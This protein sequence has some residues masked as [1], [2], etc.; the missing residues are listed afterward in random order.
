MPID[1]CQH[2]A[3]ILKDEK[4]SPIAKKR[5]IDE[6]KQ[7]L[8]LGTAGVPTPPLPCGAQ[9]P[10]VPYADLIELEDESKYPEW[11]K[12][13]LGLYEQ[14]AKGLDVKSQF[15]ILPIVDP[16]ALAVSLN[17]DIPNIK[18]PGEFALY[19]LSLPLLAFKLG[20]EP[21]DLALKFPDLIKPPIPQLN[22]PLPVDIKI[23]DFQALFDFSLWPLKLPDIIANLMLQ[24]PQLII[25]LFQFDLGAFCDAV[26]K[27]KVFGPFNPAE[28][29]VWAVSGKVLTRKTAECV[30]IAVVSSTVGTAPAGITGNL[31]KHYGYTP[32]PQE[33]KE[34]N[35][36]DVVV[37]AAKS[38]AGESWSEDKKR[39][40]DVN[41]DYTKAKLKYTQ[42]MLPHTISK[43]YDG[44][45][46]PK[47][48]KSEF[49]KQ[50]KLAYKKAKELSSC[51]L[52]VRGCYIRAGALD[53]PGVSYFETPYKAATAISGL[54]SV[55][56]KRKEQALIPFAPHNIP[57]LKRGDAVLAQRHNEPNS[58]HV[59]MLIEDYA[60]GENNEAL[61]IQG[62]APDKG[63]PG[64]TAVKESAFVFYTKGGKVWVQ[65]TLVEPQAPGDP[66]PKQQPP[67]EVLKIFDAEKMVN[68]D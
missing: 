32:P 66:E 23:P 9:F 2:H 58:E 44:T 48:N 30:S 46:D 64:P 40:K 57:A 22:L 6:V 65:S 21:P 15:T 12:N 17:L 61:G 50:T 54:V 26:A 24:M 35:I 28:A 27:S 34:Q 43:K 45:G 3:G 47:F 60:G 31:G 14:I 41:Y 42:W 33:T 52:F 4:L 49:V 5:F 25:K 36:R 8:L 19:S 56:K 13:V 29:I 37:K 55:A 1:G 51:G 63:N 11:H 18:F 53:P 59:F 67:R 7:E 39:L 62:G 68:N 16:L 10:P 38:M 20:L